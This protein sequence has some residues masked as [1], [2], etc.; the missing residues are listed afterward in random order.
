MKKQKVFPENAR[1]AE[2]LLAWK[3]LKNAIKKKFSSAYIND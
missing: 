3:K 2:N 1:Q